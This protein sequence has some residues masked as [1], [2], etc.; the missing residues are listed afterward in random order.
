MPIIDS[1]RRT[2]NRSS[3]SFCLFNSAC[4]NSLSLLNPSTCN[5]HPSIPF[6]PLSSPLPSS[7]LPFSHLILNQFR[8]QLRIFIRNMLLFDHLLH[9]LKRRSIIP[10]WIY[11]IISNF[12]TSS[13]VSFSISNANCN[14][15]FSLNRYCFLFF[16][17]NTR[18][19]I[20]ICREDQFNANSSSWECL[21]LLLSLSRT[22]LFNSA[23]STSLFLIST[24][25][26]I[27]SSGVKKS[28][29]SNCL[30]V[31]LSSRRR[32]VQ[33]KKERRV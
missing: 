3:S 26:P 1:V 19:C 32:R 6:L 7:S 17:S 27:N 5:D 15:S 11:F 30:T 28:S 22:S 9:Y 20:W 14:P 25:I 16:S 4:L 2:F 24:L 23:K 33:L 21:L 12:L 31:D 13:A 18:N 10:I 29:T 8:N